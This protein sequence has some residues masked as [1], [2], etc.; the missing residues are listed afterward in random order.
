MG[1]GVSRCHHP[2]HSQCIYWQLT[3]TTSQLKHS[4][5]LFIWKAVNDFKQV[6]QRSP[7]FPSIM[8]VIFSPPALL[9][10]L[11]DAAAAFLPLGLDA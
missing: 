11:H 10:L 3:S 8:E 7:R 9:L 1:C 5:V 6:V 4:I 2:S